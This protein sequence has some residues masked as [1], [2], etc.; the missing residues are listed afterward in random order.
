MRLSEMIIILL[1]VSGFVTGFAGFYGAMM[2][3]YDKSPE[4]FSSLEQT[5]QVY[6]RTEEMYERI[7]ATSEDQ[8][9]SGTWVITTPLNLL[10]GSFRAGL[11]ALQIPN[12]FQNLFTDLSTRVFGV[13]VWITSMVMALIF[14]MV[15]AGII[16][17]LGKEF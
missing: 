16:T 14:I 9:S 15:I 13:P 2:T 10:I 17:F 3:A 6:E 12:Y 11:L 8:I 7:N 5:T 4:N 1:L